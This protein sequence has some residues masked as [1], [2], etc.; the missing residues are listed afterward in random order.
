MCPAV[1][2]GATLS[3]KHPS[4]KSH[5]NFFYCF[6]GFFLILGTEYEDS[7]SAT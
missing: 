4:H 5:R 3:S 6:H 7:Q 2:G 1:R